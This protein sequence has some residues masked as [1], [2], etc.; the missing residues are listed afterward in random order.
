MT[1]TLMT[2]GT[3][4]LWG[5]FGQQRPHRP[6]R[7]QP[8]CRRRPPRIPAGR[9]RPGASRLSGVGRVEGSI[10]TPYAPYPSSHP[11]RS[12]PLGSES[13]LDQALSRAAT[14]PGARAFVRDCSASHWALCGRSQSTGTG[15]LRAGPGP[16]DCL[17]RPLLPRDGFQIPG[18]RHPPVPGPSVGLVGALGVAETL[19][20]L[21]RGPG[22]V[23]F[24]CPF[25]HAGSPRVR[26]D[27]GP[28]R[29]PSLGR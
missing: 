22:P 16:E 10:L 13:A 27:R 28:D 24:Q 8:A 29:P 3:C 12:R 15:L 23:S 4:S 25:T 6:G 26:R 11:S 9:L 1:I 14:H 21:G 19:G 5:R 7:T 20:R 2:I 17:T 18:R